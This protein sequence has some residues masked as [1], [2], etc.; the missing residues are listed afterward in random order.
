MEQGLNL[1]HRLSKGFLAEDRMDWIVDL[2][3]NS[4]VLHLGCADSGFTDLNAGRERLMHARLD[5]ACSGVV[6]A[7][8]DIPAIARMRDMGFDDV[9]C[10]DI[11][12]EPG[13]IAKAIKEQM[14]TCD[15]IVC[16]EVLEHLVDHRSFLQGVKTVASQFGAEL[17]VTV[18]NAFSIEGALQVVFGNE[19][20]H[21]DHKCYYS[22][23]TLRTL[24][25]T[26]GFEIARLGFYSNRAYRSYARKLAKSA[27]RHTLLSFR[28]QFGEGILVVAKPHSGKNGG[29]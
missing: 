9:V 17:V 11:S 4:N 5:S 20:V 27:L 24:L 6:G 15:Y 23:V 7:D 21:P 13:D 12:R 10:V 3:K 28:P 14:G 19:R 16:G 26:N 25:E 2:V 1:D 8:V 29:D 22:E 18:P